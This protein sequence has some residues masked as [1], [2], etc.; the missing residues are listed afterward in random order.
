MQR[1][2]IQGQLPT[3][4]DAINKARTHWAIS[5]KQKKEATELVALQCKRMKKIETPVF[6]TFH[7]FIST[8]HDPDNIRSAAKY[9]MDGLIEAKK[10]PN[11]NQKWILGFH[12]DYFTVVPK[13]QEKIIVE[14]DDGSEL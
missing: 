11:D 2:T 5:A 10:L 14:I 8:R 4:N 3:L 6:I 9:V 7:W 13:G 12:G 1:V